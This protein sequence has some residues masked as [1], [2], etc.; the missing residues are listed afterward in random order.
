MFDEFERLPPTF[1]THAAEVLGAT[2]GGLSGSEIARLLR[3]RR[4]RH[5]GA[6]LINVLWAAP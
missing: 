2:S 5:D 3:G 6:A 1:I 4:T